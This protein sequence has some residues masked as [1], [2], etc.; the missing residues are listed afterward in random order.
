MSALFPDHLISKAEEEI[1]HHED[2]RTPSSSSKGQQLLFCDRCSKGFELCTCNQEGLLLCE[3][4]FKDKNSFTFHLYIHSFTLS[5]VYCH[6]A[7]HVPFA[8]GLPQKKGVNPD[9]QF[10]KSNKI[11]EGCFLC[12]SLE[13]CTKCHKCPTCCTKSTC[14]GQITPVWGK[15][16][17]PR[18]QPQ[19][20]SSSQRRLHTS[21]PVPAQSDQ[22][23]H[24]NKQLCKS[25]QEQLPV[26]GMHQMLDK[27][28]VELVQNPQSLGFYNWLFL[29]PKPN[30]RWHPILDLW[31]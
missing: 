27:N 4:K 30:N 25:L 7:N 16:G 12:K 15:M 9:H 18:R 31:I 1:R 5:P 29:V 20:T 2:K 8:G 24:N 6:V 28:A 11:H 21:L 22:K 19:S 3:P 17:S 13:F 26:G 23:S 10:A 14:R